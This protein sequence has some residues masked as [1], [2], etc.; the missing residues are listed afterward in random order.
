MGKKIIKKMII[1]IVTWKFT[2]M[3]RLLICAL[4]YRSYPRS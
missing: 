4:A 2:I 3:Q 1:Y